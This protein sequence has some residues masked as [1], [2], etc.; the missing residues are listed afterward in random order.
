MK[1]LVDCILCWI[2]LIAYL[3]SCAEDTLEKY[4]LRLIIRS[5]DKSCAVVVN[6]SF[7]DYDRRA[8]ILYP[9]ID[10]DPK[11]FLAEKT[12]MEWRASYCTALDSPKNEEDVH[13]CFTAN[14]FLPFTR[15]NTD[16]GK[17]CQ[18]LSCADEKLTICGSDRR[19]LSDINDF[20]G[21]MREL[22]ET[23]HN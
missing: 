17:A 9:A 20:Y 7:L 15:N 13:S 10:N 8:I 1:I 3:C 23:R 6:Q 2:A 21:K 12:P 22:R 16:N 19:L 4:N 11:T 5:S 14:G 18:L